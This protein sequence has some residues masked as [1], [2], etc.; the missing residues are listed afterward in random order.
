MVS[1]GNLELRELLDL[2]DPRGSR[3]QSDLVA[4]LVQMEQPAL[5]ALQAQLEHRVQSDP[6][7][8][9][10]KLAPEAKLVQRAIEASLALKALLAQL[11]Q[12]DQ[13]A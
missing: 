1:K 13:E 12:S 8:S 11:A 2:L 3:V 10:G 4:Y 6:K 5:E 9:K 7:A